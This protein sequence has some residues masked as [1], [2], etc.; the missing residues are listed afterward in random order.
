[1]KRTILALPL[2]LC[3]TLGHSRAD[4]PVIDGSAI[5]RWIQQA[6]QMEQQLQQAQQTVHALENV[7][8]GM[9][10]QFQGL[11]SSLQ[12]PLGNI[13]LN[14]NTLLTGAGSGS[15]GGASNLLNMTQMFTAAPTL[16]GGANSIDFAGAQ[17]N[18][19][20]A[21]LAGLTACTRVMMDNTQQRMNQLPPLID[22]LKGCGDV[23]CTTA[24]QGQIQAM[25]ADATMQIQQAL[26]VGQNAQLGEM[27]RRA[28]QEQKMRADEK[29]IIDATG[30]A[31]AI[32]GSGPNI[33]GP[34]TAAPT[35]N[36]LNFTPGG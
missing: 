2:A 26:L 29:R 3:L 25:Q 20:A 4:L 16:G 28:Q 32:G 13:N 15:C 17:L 5:V 27:I 10:G 19:Q 14:L 1:M 31:G 8:R 7:P 33:A 30:G 11:F 21:Q 36:A 6:Q 34:T 9:I 12:N 22:Q 23:A 18:G 35:F 24:V